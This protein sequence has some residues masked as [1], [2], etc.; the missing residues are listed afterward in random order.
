MDGIGALMKG[1]PRAPSPLLPREGAVR[2]WTA[3]VWEGVPAGT[4]LGQHP[5]LGLPAFGTVSDK[6][7][8]FLSPVCGV[9][10]QEPAWAESPGCQKPHVHPQ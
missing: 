10:L 9:L 8:S 7:L 3:A 1:H 6:C 4:W 5:D 2:S